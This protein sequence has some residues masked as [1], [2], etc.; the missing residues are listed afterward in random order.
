MNYTGSK[1]A[2][3]E[4]VAREIGNTMRYNM[5]LSVDWKVNVVITTKCR[6]S[7]NDYIKFDIAQNGR[8]T[9]HIVKAEKE[10]W[11]KRLLKRI[12]LWKCT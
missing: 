8:V 10:C 12:G 4:A 1:K 3:S 9:H 7:D 2:I 6:S 5:P 11:F